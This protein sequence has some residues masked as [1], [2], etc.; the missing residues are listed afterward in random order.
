MIYTEQL[1]QGLGVVGSIHS[2][3]Q[4]VGSSLTE[5]IDLSKGRRFLF[6][7]DV[8]TVG[9]SATVD[10]VVQGATTSGGTYTNIAATAVTTITANNKVAVV[11]VTAE[12]VQGLGL[13]YTFLKGKL[14]IGVAASQAS[15]VAYSA[16]TRNEPSSL[17]NQGYVAAPVVF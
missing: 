5:A 13:G 1:S 3:N 15:V 12:Q 14:T 6:V 7:V 4:V 16:V 11:E 17:Q 2:A 9:A 8:G 10:F